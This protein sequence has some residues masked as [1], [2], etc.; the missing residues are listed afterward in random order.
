MAVSL[1]TDDPAISAIDLAHE[2]AFAKR[3]L[4]FTD[5]E[6]EELNRRAMGSAFV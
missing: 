4:R 1:N 5:A 3:V 6:L 2:Y